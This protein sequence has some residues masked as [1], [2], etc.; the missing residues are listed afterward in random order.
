MDTPAFLSL[1]S[2]S[3]T[4]CLSHSG[5]LTRKLI[6]SQTWKL[7][8]AKKLPGDQTFSLPGHQHLSQ[9]ATAIASTTTT[10][11]ATTTTATTSRPT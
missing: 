6:L 8:L 2:H 7:F 1:S 5:F 4:L 3:L 9:P 10:T 11:T